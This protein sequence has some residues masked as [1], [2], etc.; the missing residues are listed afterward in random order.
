MCW[1]S[2]TED[3]GGLPHTARGSARTSCNLQERVFGLGE[4]TH[5]FL[6]ADEGPVNPRV[7]NTFGIS[8]SDDEAA[9]AVRLVNSII[10]RAL[11]EGPRTSMWSH[12]LDS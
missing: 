8:R 3:A 6:E 7:D 11:S 10:G 5:E 9:P 2:T 4:D 12:E 1:R